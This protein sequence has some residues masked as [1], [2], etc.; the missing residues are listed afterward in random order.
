M[1]INLGSGCSEVI[2]TGPYL[3]GK[4]LQL[5]TEVQGKDVTP[6]SIRDDIMKIKRIGVDQ[7]EGQ[8]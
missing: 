4:I 7:S 2:K 5:W 3:V 6:A 1:V 8:N